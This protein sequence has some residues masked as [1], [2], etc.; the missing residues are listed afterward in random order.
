MQVGKGNFI[1]AHK[2]TYQDKQFDSIA[3]K[4][5]FI[6]LSS[7]MTDCLILRPCSIKLK[8]KLRQ[9]KC[10]F[11]IVPRTIQARDRL[12]ELRDILHGKKYP[13]PV[14]VLYFEYKGTTDL[15]TGLARLDKNFI[16]R[17]NHLIRY[18]PEVLSNFV[19]VGKGT[20]GITGYCTNNSFHVMP[21]HSESFLQKILGEI[22]GNDH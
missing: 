9:W 13:N 4:N 22:Y 7:Y 21:V 6:L 20:G 1:K 17:M 10:D 14:D 15:T 5:V 8:G 19:C 18:E 2:C 11:G 12:T 3:E 16:D